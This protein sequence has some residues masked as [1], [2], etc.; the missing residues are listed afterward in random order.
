MVGGS[1][2]LALDSVAVGDEDVPASSALLDAVVGGGRDSADDDLGGAATLVTKSGA[3]CASFSLPVGTA[4]DSAA[5]A[6]DVVCENLGSW[7]TFHLR[8]CELIMPVVVVVVVLGAGVGGFLD[9]LLK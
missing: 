2:E 8:A 7:S 5:G 9:L 4:G 1:S 3:T 6:N